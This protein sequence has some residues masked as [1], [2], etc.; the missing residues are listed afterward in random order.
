[1]NVVG[2][3]S[4]LDLIP[5]GWRRCFTAE[6]G[7]KRSMK[8]VIEIIGAFV[9]TTFSRL[10]N[11]RLL[12]VINSSKQHSVN[13]TKAERLYKIQTMTESNPSTVTCG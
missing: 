6:P 11:L 1:M 12:G 8:C 13:E 10:L 3:T 9:F 2:P 5:E 4:S 7:W